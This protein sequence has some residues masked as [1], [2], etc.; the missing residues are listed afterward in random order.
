M[1]Q[2]PPLVESVQDP[3]TYRLKREIFCPEARDFAYGLHGILDKSSY[4]RVQGGVKKVAKFL[5]F[6]NASLN[7]E[8]SISQTWFKKLS[9]EVWLGKIKSN[10]LNFEH[11]FLYRTEADLSQLAN[12]ANPAISLLYD[13]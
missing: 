1:E 11:C 7:F 8:C 4:F 6:W 10:A 5:P 13:C 12:P 2:P 9:D 3:Q